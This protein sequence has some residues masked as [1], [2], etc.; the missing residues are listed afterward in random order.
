[1]AIGFQ[2]HIINVCK[3]FIPDIKLLYLFGSHA[4]NQA[5]TDSDIDLAVLLP[6]KISPVARWELQHRLSLEFNVDV[7]LVDLLSASTVMQNQII[8]S[9]VCLFDESNYQPAFEMQVMSMYQHLNE[10][11]ASVLKAFKG[12]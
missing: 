10:E 7:D 4:S 6:S 2:S 9:G 8:N 11:R 3:Q 1:M 12:S 5:N